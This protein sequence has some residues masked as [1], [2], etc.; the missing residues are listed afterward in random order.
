MFCAIFLFLRKIKN[1]VHIQHNLQILYFIY[2]MDKSVG[3]IPDE[4]LANGSHQIQ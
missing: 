4:F 3:D 1:T 2:E